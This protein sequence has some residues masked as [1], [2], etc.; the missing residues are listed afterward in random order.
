MINTTGLISATE[1]VITFQPGVFEAIIGEGKGSEVKH[2]TLSKRSYDKQSSVYEKS[3][4]KYT[5]NTDDGNEAK[6]RVRGQGPQMS[7]P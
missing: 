6:G 5:L 7:R 1:H 2:T 4:A 3:V